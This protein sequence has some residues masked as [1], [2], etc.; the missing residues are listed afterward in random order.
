[1]KNDGIKNEYKFIE[2]LNNKRVYELEYLFREFIL[3]LF[4]DCTRNSIVRC[5]KGVHY[6]KVD[7]II[8]IGSRTKNISIKKGHKN[9]VHCEKISKFINFLRRLNFDNKIINEI[10][11]YHFADG[12]IDGTGKNRIDSREYQLKNSYS[13]GI[14]NKY[15]NN[16]KFIKKMVNRFIIQGTQIQSKCVDVLVYGTPSD[17]IY[18]TRNEI[19]NFLLSKTN[20]ES[21]AIHFSCLTFQ[22]LSRVLDYD[23]SKEYMRGWLQIKWYNL[24]DNIIEIMNRRSCKNT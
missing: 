6:E 13:I 19:Y 15:I 17:F 14:I 2:K 22:S 7:I 3:K 20:F 16:K 4:P 10:L 21:K 1:M 12:T 8:S 9:S 18:V 24:E 5:K 11:K 23:K